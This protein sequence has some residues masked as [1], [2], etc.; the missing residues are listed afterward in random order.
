M[1][2]EV[3]HYFA[4]PPLASDP[5]PVGS[6]SAF[7]I[8]RAHK[9]IHV[10]HD[11]F[12]T[13]ILTDGEEGTPPRAFARL[14]FTFGGAVDGDGN[15][16]D[17]GNE[18]E[19]QECCSS[20]LFLP[21]IMGSELFEDNTKRWLPDFIGGGSDV[22]ALY[23]DEMGESVNA[24]TVGEVIR[25]AYGIADLYGPFI[26]ALEDVRAAGS[27]SGY[28]TYA[29]D[30]RLSIPAIIEGGEL[31][32][33]L[34]ELALSSQTGK[35]TIVAHSNGGLVAKALV[36][37]LD[38][39]ASSLVDDVVLVAVPQ[40]GT[41]QAMGVLLH[42]FESGLPFTWLPISVSAK[43]ARAFA[44]TSPMTYHLLPH[45]EY[46]E[47]GGATVSTALATFRE[48]VPE[49][50][51]DRYGTTIDTDE[52]FLQFIT[53]S[54]GRFTPSFSD[55]K[56]PGVGK[57]NLL[58][59]SRSYLEAISAGWQPPSGITVHQ[60]A[61][62]GE[63]TLSSITYK[64]GRVACTELITSPH[65]T[66]RCARYEEGILYTPERVFDGDGTV[67]TPSAL[68]MSDESEQVTR[69]WVNLREYNGFLTEDVPILNTFRTRHAAI[70]T[71]PSVHSL[72]VNN[73]IIN[74]LDVLPQ[75]VYASAQN[76]PSRKRLDFVLHS[77]LILSAIDS[78][79]NEYV[80]T[81]WGEVQTLS[82]PEGVAFTLML[83]GYEDGLF[84]LD[85]EEYED[86]VKK[87]TSTFSG[88]PTL[89]HTTASMSFTDA[90][91]ADA[92]GLAI[93]FYGD[94]QVQITL[95]PI[96]NETVVM[97][98]PE[99]MTDTAPEQISLITGGGPLWN[100]PPEQ[101]PEAPL[102]IEVSKPTLVSTAEQLP[103]QVLN[104][105]EIAQEP[106]VE[107]VDVQL[108][109]TESEISTSS[110]AYNI[111]QTASVL[112]AGEWYDLMVEFFKKITQRIIKFFR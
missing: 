17:E 69:W 13:W 62:V 97:P 30:W 15:E 107:Q 25:N 105:Q 86:G 18:P 12:V 11:D 56:N 8:E 32:A 54:E 72:I 95:T 31:E 50:F 58:A 38:A 111:S 61:G 45:A 81:T 71:I 84:T 49:M 88:I 63:E 44:S 99:Q 80:A 57:T 53:A 59:Q 74:S 5:P 102:T 19:Y 52:E 20:V 55:L 36:N 64:K 83:E 90:T 29:Y 10:P 24:I 98:E 110:N 60:I 65:S 41:P 70:L 28:A 43:D 103:P 89:E 35:V 101:T 47:H 108:T 39:D 1:S 67:V 33:L 82:I 42:G 16:G 26:D 100:T 87:N 73:L 104:T 78:E 9:H 75:Y 40:L 94:G 93:D 92:S 48:S 22:R 3:G 96:L 85:I 66:P 77:P 21:G 2:G 4:L 23:L 6:Y 79:G 91:L 109:A 27:I 37:A 76:F 112:Q 46:F 68:A 34:R 106:E 7:I 51:T 14:D